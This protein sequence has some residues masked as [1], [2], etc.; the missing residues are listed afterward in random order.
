MTDD[1][2]ILIRNLYYMLTYAFRDLR[3]N[4]YEDIAG[5]DFDNILDLFAEILFK[6]ISFQLKRGLHKE[7]ASH[8]D[9]LASMKGK[10]D[11][12]ASIRLRI[13]RKMQIAC[14]F[15]EFTENNLHNS[16]LKATIQ[17]LL[18]SDDV[19]PKRRKELKNILLF[20]SQVDSCDLK[21]VRWSDIIYDR[22]TAT[23]RMLHHF[24]YFVVQKLLLTTETGA[25][26]VMTF[27]EEL[28]SRLFEKFVLSFY[29]RHYPQYSARAAKVEWNIDR[30]T[31][32]LSVI[33]ELQ[34]D[35]TLTFP[36]RTLI[37]DT[38]YYGQS[39]QMHMGKKT[40]HSNNLFQIHTYVVN[41]D[42]EHSG[43]VDGM[44]LYAKT[45]EEIVTD[46]QMNTTDGNTIYFRTLDLNQD[47]DCIKQQ[48]EELV[49]PY[50]FQ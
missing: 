11:I 5:E 27:D 35:I 50:C 7:Y 3:Q 32:S 10:I 33:P 40:I 42:K 28:M 38:K 36:N 23:Y 17:L 20:F 26:K 25:Y 4:N 44:L 24:C 19:K 15:D 49:K 47:F 30:E 16:I 6:G 1:K 18:K 21:Y 14:N 9:N 12:D 8:S 29:R 43:K 13:Q 37:I 34:T 31:S 41:E 22:N 39:V 46:G 48:L 45:Q 2:G